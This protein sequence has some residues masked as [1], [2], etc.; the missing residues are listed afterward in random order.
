MKIAFLHPDLG[1]GGAE[2]LIIDAAMALTDKVRF[3][4]ART[5]PTFTSTQRHSVHMFTSHYEA[6]RSFE[7]TRNGR[8]PVTVYGDWMPRQLFGQLHILFAI[9]R[10]MW[11]ALMICVFEPQFDVFICDQVLL[12]C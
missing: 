5:C 2:R 7:E 8:F 12:L 4:A 3:P 1:L 6:E 10:N 11:L 9:L